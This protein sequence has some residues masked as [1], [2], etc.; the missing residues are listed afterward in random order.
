MSSRYILKE[1]E[2]IA[3]VDN[4]I[5]ILRLVVKTIKISLMMTFLN[6]VVQKYSN[7]A[8]LDKSGGLLRIISDNTTPEWMGRADDLSGKDTSRNRPLGTSLINLM[9]NSIRLVT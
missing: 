4:I 9:R 5:T 8:D 1:R 3:S 7:S 2:I 6:W